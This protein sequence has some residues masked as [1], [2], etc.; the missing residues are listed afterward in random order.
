MKFL[1]LQKMMT[2][3]NLKDKTV[4]A[5]A[6]H[7]QRDTCAMILGKGGDYLFGLKGNQERII[8]TGGKTTSEILSIL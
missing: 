5:D 1:C 4:T 3:L 8:T 7:C 6:M 2:Y